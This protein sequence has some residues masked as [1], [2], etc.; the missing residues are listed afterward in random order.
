MKLI[1]I[2]FAAITVARSDGPYAQ[3]SSQGLS[4]PQQ[5]Q[6]VSFKSE[7]A[8]GPPSFSS[9]SFSS[10][11]APYPSSSG[12]S[13]AQYSTSSGPYPSHAEGPY[14]PSADESD[15]QPYANSQVRHK[16][17]EVRILQEAHFNLILAEHG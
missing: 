2:L 10:V 15:I 9:G 4:A 17:C 3:Q 13:Q 11:S 6:Q 12:Q 16:I 5:Q 7:D 8:Y 1:L 14:P